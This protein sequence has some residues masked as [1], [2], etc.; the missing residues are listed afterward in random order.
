MI[1]LKAK[2]SPLFQDVVLTARFRS[3]KLL[4]TTCRFQAARSKKDMYVN[5]LLSKLQVKKNGL[6][7]AEQIAKFNNQALKCCLRLGSVVADVT[8]GGGRLSQCLHKFL[9]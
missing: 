1:I 8:K 7:K 9:C 6:T 4:E 3:D 2:Q 5:A